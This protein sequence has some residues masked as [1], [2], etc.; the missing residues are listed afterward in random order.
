MNRVSEYL[1]L[2]GV[3]DPGVPDLEAL[4][5]LQQRHLLA[6]PFENLSVVAGEAIL[7][8]EELL[9]AKLLDRRRGG[10]CYELNGAFAWLLRQLGYH[11][12]VIE[13]GVYSSE[14]GRPGPQFDHM[15]L[16]VDLDRRYFVDV[17]FGDSARTPVA[18]PDGEVEDVSGRY[19][20]HCS[21]TASAFALERRQARAWSP[22]VIFRQQPR[23][24]PDFQD[25]C[26]YHCTDPR[27]TFVRR[28]PVVTRALRGGRITLTSD[29]LTITDHGGS[30]RRQKV[31]GRA[32]F[33]SFLGRHFG[34]DLPAAVED[35]EGG[36]A[37]IS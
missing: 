9:V 31:A 10:F 5:R 16:I 17:G 15:A 30:K 6:V 11:V 7:L 20:L 18:L 32:D 29:S 25:R 33:A 4:T 3:Q 23:Q 28:G 1:H 35:W 36:E 12:T 2:L 34:M 19:R 22:L 13:G 14:T 27:S 37:L 24:L 21:A 26:H 8:D